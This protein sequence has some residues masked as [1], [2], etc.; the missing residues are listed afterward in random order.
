[1]P[2]MQSLCGHAV[3]L[4]HLQ[5]CRLGVRVQGKQIKGLIG[6]IQSKRIY[7]SVFFLPLTTANSK[8]FCIAAILNDCQIGEE[9]LS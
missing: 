6:K 1:M 4:L 2:D 7:C 3:L 5:F 8:I 9:S